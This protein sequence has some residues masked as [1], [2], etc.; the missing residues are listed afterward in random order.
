MYRDHEACLSCLAYES[1]E[2]SN[3]IRLFMGT[4]YL[5]GQRA[6][7][8]LSARQLAS[9]VYEFSGLWTVLLTGNS[10]LVASGE[11]STLSL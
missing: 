9:A 3:Q 10:L 2:P 1:T 6:M 8:Q 5:S 4:C 7:L 11:Y